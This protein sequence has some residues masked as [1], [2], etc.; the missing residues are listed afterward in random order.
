[1]KK[2]VERRLS[3]KKSSLKESHQET[4]NDEK[5]EKT[6]KSVNRMLSEEEQNES[7]DPWKDI[8]RGSAWDLQGRLTGVSEIFKLGLND[9]KTVDDDNEALSNGKIENPS[10]KQKRGL[11]KNH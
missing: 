5:R 6:T 11:R 1:L 10:K 8:E 7:V 3:N 2:R 4:K 9:I